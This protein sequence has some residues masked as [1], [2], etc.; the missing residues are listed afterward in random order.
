MSQNNTAQLLN[1]PQL[2]LKFSMDFRKH[3]GING[4]Q[5]VSIC[6]LNW[7]FNKKWQRVWDNTPWVP[8]FQYS[9][10]SVKS[11]ATFFL[12]QPICGWTC[13]SLTKAEKSDKCFSPNRKPL[14]LNPE[15]MEEVQMGKVMKNFYQGLIESITLNHINFWCILQNLLWQ[16][17]N[18]KSILRELTTRNYYLGFNIVILQLLHELKDKTTSSGLN[19]VPPKFICW[20]PNPHCDGIWTWAFG[21]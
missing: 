6:S 19:Y 5:Y 18:P 11:R 17:I 20:W 16:I 10:F 8:R 12:S 4:S 15:R 7:A 2:W 21:R 1:Y 14:F 9:I 3:G 13:H